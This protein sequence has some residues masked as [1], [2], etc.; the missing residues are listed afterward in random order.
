M[1]THSSLGLAP[2]RFS[3]IVS[4]D[5]VGLIVNRIKL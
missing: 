3:Y 2:V 5:N 1:E 4:H